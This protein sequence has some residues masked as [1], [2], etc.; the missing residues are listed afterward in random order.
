MD[1]L[2]R[3]IARGLSLLRCRGKHELHA[4]DYW[5]HPDFKCLQVSPDVEPPPPGV[6]V[7]KRW[8]CWRCGAVFN[9]KGRIVAWNE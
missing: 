4:A 3:G 1:A 7:H 5:L 2:A 8:E 9:G 6:H